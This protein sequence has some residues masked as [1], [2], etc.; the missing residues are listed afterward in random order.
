LLLYVQKAA[1]EKFV[2]ILNSSIKSPVKK[3][4]WPKKWAGL[5]KKIEF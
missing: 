5:K 2:K 1:K 4:P 3:L